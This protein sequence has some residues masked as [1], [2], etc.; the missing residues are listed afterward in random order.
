MPGLF[1]KLLKPGYD[2][3]PEVEGNTGLK[4]QCLHGSHLNSSVHLYDGDGEEGDRE[5]RDPEQVGR[6]DHAGHV[7]QDEEE[8]GHQPGQDQPA[9]V[10]G[11][12][13]HQHHAK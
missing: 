7:G 2:A 8:R 13:V 6:E 5:E 4:T 9:G 12:A 10:L 11:G 1:C 3:E